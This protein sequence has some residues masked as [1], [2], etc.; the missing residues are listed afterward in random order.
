MA[1]H[2]QDNARQENIKEASVAH[3][4]LWQKIKAKMSDVSPMRYY[5]AIILLLI[6]GVVLF[7]HSF[8]VIWAGLGIVAILAVYEATKL[9]NSANKWLIVALATLFW[10][11]IF[12]F[13]KPLELLFLILMVFAS[14][15]AF[16]QKGDYKDI[17]PFIYPLAPFIFLL[18]IYRDFGVGVLLWL[19]VVVILTDCG[20]FFGGKL[21]GASPF[22]KTSPKKTREGVLVGVFVASFVG[23]LCGLIHV[24]FWVA[25]IMSFLVSLASVF[26]DLYE[27]LLKRKASVKDSGKLLLGHGGVLDRMDGFLFAG[28]AFYLLLWVIEEFSL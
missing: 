26:G 23:T 4:T 7:Y 16:T 22:C 24:S 5:T 17:M 3:A 27:S 1:E 10:C 28:I 20:G 2:S 13:S 19:I 14:F 12:Y 21:L 8:L 9:F 6:L 15:Q 25:F 18:L 11:A